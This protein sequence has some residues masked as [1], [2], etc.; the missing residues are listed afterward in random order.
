MCRSSKVHMCDMARIF[1]DERRIKVAK[2]IRR[3]AWKGWLAGRPCL[4]NVQRRQ[5]TCDTP[6]NVILMQGRLVGPGQNLG[7]KNG[8]GIWV[9]TG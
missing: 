1:T 7:V 3:L 5:C 9:V 2:E 6:S 8:N 4:D